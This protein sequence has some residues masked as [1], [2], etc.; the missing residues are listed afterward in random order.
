MSLIGRGSLRWEPHRGLRVDRDLSLYYV[1]FAHGS[2]AA[3]RGKGFIVRRLLLLSLTLLL[4]VA[5][6]VAPASAGDKLGV[7]ISTIDD[8]AP[9]ASEGTFLV[10]GDA[11]GFLCDSGTWISTSTRL[12]FISE[13]TFKIKAERKFTC[14]LG[15][16][17]V[18]E[19]KNTIVLGEGGIPGKGT[20]KLKES[21]GFDP[22]PKGKGEILVG[23]GGEVYEGLLMFK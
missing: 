1:A 21:T 5:F 10:S 17:F 19:L 6:A 15:E 18:L 13:D 9:P 12:W 8:P 4:L 22:A 11:A 2:M 14:D 20:W 23:D 16:T 3:R 7:S